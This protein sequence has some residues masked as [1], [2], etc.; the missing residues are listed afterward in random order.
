MKT[1]KKWATSIDDNTAEVIDRIFQS[2]NIKEQ[3]YNL[4]LSVLKLSKPYSE[5]HL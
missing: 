2:V 1:I 4:A 3:G 5:K